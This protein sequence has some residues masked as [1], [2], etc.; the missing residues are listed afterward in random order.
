M[1]NIFG[2]DK[3]S[4]TTSTTTNYS[5][6]D[7]SANAG[8]NDSVAVGSGASVSI[9]T[10]DPAIVSRALSTA[11]AGLGASLAT[12][13][14]AEREGTTRY[15]ASL[16]AI[17]SDADSARRSEE[18]VRQAAQTAIDTTAGLAQSL[19]AQ[20]ADSKKDPNN[21]T[22]ETAAKYG[23]TAVAFVAVAIAAV[24]YLRKK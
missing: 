3:K 19:S 22:L 2:S 9:Q 15:L 17:R 16:E 1:F 6:T 12:V 14:N 24:Y 7:E 23:A 5:H 13:N 4:S 21:Q 18:S 8:G 20:V 11:E 10:S